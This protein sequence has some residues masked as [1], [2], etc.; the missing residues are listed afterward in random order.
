MI[1]KGGGKRESRANKQDRERTTKRSIFLRIGLTP[2]S[3]RKKK[4]VEMLR[5]KV[6]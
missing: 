6:F 5:F 1:R 2:S 4:D 3:S